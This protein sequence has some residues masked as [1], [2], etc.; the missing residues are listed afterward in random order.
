[1]SNKERP[2]D[3]LINDPAAVEAMKMSSPHVAMFDDYMKKGK[4][5]K[6]QERYTNEPFIKRIDMSQYEE[7]LAARN[8]GKQIRNESIRNMDANQLVDMLD[9]IEKSIDR[10]KLLNKG[11]SP[12]LKKALQTKGLSKSDISKMEVEFKTNLP[13]EAINSLNS[14][15]GNA[16]QKG[17]KG[18]VGGGLVGTALGGPIGGML[19]VYLG[20]RLGD[21]VG[22]GLLS[23]KQASQVQNQIQQQDPYG[24][25]GKRVYD[26][27]MNDFL[28]NLNTQQQA[29]PQ[30]QPGISNQVLH[31]QMQAM[32]NQMNQMSQRINQQPQ[33]QQQRP[34]QPT[35]Q[36]QQQA[37]PQQSQQQA[38]PQ[39]QQTPPPTPQPA[40]Q[41]KP[42]T[43]TVTP[44]SGT[45]SYTPPVAKPSAAPKVAAKPASAPKAAPA[46]ATSP[47]EVAKRVRS[48][49]SA[50]KTSVKKPEPAPVDIHA[51]PTPVPTPWRR[52]LE[53]R[54]YKPEEVD[55]MSFE[56]AK[57]LATVKDVKEVP[58]M[59]TKKTPPMPGGDAGLVR[60]GRRKKVVDTNTNPDIKKPLV[61]DDVITKVANMV[62]AGKNPA[63]IKKFLR[64][65]GIA[66]DK[67]NEILSISGGMQKMRKGDIAP[68]PEKKPVE[69]RKAIDSVNYAIDMIKKSAPWVQEDKAM[70]PQEETSSGGDKNM[71]WL[72][73]ALEGG[74][75]GVLAKHPVVG[76]N[77]GETASK[78]GSK[79]LET[80]QEKGKSEDFDHAD[81]KAL[82]LAILEALDGIVSGSGD[83]KIGKSWSGV[84]STLID[85][86]GAPAVQEIAQGMAAQKGGTSPINTVH[87]AVAEPLGAGEYTSKNKK[88]AK[89][90]F[91]GQSEVYGDGTNMDTESLTEE[92]K[93]LET[94]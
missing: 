20:D 28:N 86:Y 13:P 8:L 6:S 9:R 87:K 53:S 74:A 33:Q 1:M 3:L 64:S 84:M 5:S 71:A 37:A 62:D 63:V 18:A 22:K 51:I 92:S 80:V 10:P 48:K 34:Q 69:L 67:I 57:K 17:W 41:P 35:P 91:G 79:F 21:A 23:R 81:P 36:Q 26:K 68:L 43:Q 49:T 54:G 31:A 60:G 30:Q 85:K 29:A 42:Q 76:N 82:G 2:E 55:K 27:L 39:Q 83:A 4:V 19:G 32:I 90:D 52:I 73:H 24:A 93:K 88:K 70:T 66:D 12:D 58:T 47:S 14:F 45:P 94:A 46:V 78:I 50:N 25:I 11:F 75:L 61:G 38:A 7:P 40:A 44:S 89:T 15:V 72:S 65:Q 16:V 77:I 56:E 59:K